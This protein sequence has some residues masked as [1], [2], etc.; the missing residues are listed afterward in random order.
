MVLTAFYKS[1]RGACEYIESIDQSRKGKQSWRHLAVRP[2][3]LCNVPTE[4][5]HRYTARLSVCRP[6]CFQT[7]VFVV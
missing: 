4:R 3:A 1:K 2:F 5:K 7:M 6:R